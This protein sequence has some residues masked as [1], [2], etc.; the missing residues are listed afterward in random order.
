MEWERESWLEEY[1]AGE[2]VTEIARRHGISRKALYKWIGRYQEYGLEGLRDL[3]RA[4]HQRPNQVEPVWRERVRAVR[5]AHPRW[6]ARKLAYKLEQQYGAE[7]A[8]SASTIGRLLQEMGLSQA[9]RR[10]PRANGS[11]PLW[12]A[13][14]P[15][16]VWAV[17]FKG[18]C[19][20]GDGKH[21]EPL[22]ITDQATRY[23]LCCRG[24]ESIRSELVRPVI[25]RV[26]AEYGLPQRMRSDNGPPF[27]SNG[28]CGLTELSVWWIE[29]GIEC[30]RIQRGRPQQNGRHERM[31]RTLKE[32]TMQPPAATL[33]QQQARFNSFRQE[34]NEHRPHEGWA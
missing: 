34:Y 1:E 32:A 30:E 21:C 33:R 20:T 17:D 18:W 16:E 26:F 27:A 19:R 9:K 25:E 14:Q 29:L 5:Q 10:M 23:L 7:A 28:A 8:P 2:P 24:L 6:G 11:G 12:D 31:H 15:N 4:P 3:S 22:T 13:Q